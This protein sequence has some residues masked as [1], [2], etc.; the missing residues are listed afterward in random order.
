MLYLDL[1]SV[2]SHCIPSDKSLL[3]GVSPDLILDWLII[4]NTHCNVMSSF[5]VGIVV[6]IILVSPL[7]LSDILRVRLNFLSI[8]GSVVTGMVTPEFLG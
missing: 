7:L 5:C 2:I 8:L 3:N 1:Q 4:I 6:A